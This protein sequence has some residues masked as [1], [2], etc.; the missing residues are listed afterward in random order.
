MRAV[1]VLAAGALLFAVQAGAGDGSTPR[2]LAAAEALSA[3]VLQVL[4][5]LRSEY[6]LGPLRPSPALEAAAE[7]HS[8]EMLEAG[9]FAHDSADGSRYWE[10]VARFY[11][12]GAKPGRWTVGENLFW[13]APAVSAAQ[14]IRMWMKSP[15]HRVN[16]LSPG[17]HDVGI[18]AIR[19]QAVPGAFMGLT[20]T[21][22]TVDF[23][24][25]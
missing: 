11:P 13:A 4:N 15:H 5:D 7:A 9:Y 16:L 22:L 8:T 24:V 6:G 23:G 17:W 1:L 12:P 18:S 19:A 21:V 25:R 10:R 2:N 14:A 20:V 3:R